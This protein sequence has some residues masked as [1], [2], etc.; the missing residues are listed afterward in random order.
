MKREITT[1]RFT[2]GETRAEIDERPDG[3]PGAVRIEGPITALIVERIAAAIVELRDRQHID[4]CADHG[5]HTAAEI[6]ANS[7][8]CPECLP[9]QSTKA[10]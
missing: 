9:L 1:H 10:A 6:R 5:Y 2:D 7:Y 3:I 4:L 8:R